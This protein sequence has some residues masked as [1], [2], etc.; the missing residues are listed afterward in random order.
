MSWKLKRLKSD[1]ENLREDSKKSGE[2]ATRWEDEKNLRE[3]SK[4]D[5][6]TEVYAT[7][8]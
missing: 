6:Q 2:G 3:N 8:K 5:A 4:K 1:R 7:E